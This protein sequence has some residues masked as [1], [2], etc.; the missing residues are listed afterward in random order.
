[1]ENMYL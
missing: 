1:M